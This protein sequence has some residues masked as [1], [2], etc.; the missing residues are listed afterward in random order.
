MVGYKEDSTWLKIK[1]VKVNASILSFDSETGSS[2]PR[3]RDVMRD[4]ACMFK[5]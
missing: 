3:N 2:S 4:L 5:E 1:F